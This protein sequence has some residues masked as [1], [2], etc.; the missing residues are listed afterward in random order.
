VD[1]CLRK[2]REQ[3]FETA[4]DLAAALLPFAPKRARAAVERAMAMARSAGQSNRDLE[5]TSLAHPSLPL[6]FGP[7]TGAPQSPMS[8]GPPM[9]PTMPSAQR[10]RAAESAP[11]T[12]SAPPRGFAEKRSTSGQ[13]ATTAPSG[14]D[15]PQKRRGLGA[16]A[17]VGA[18]V[19]V[20]A[21]TAWGVLRARSSSEAFTAV[22]PEA[23][24]A[25]A[26][27]PPNAAMSATALVSATAAA[28]VAAPAPVAAAVQEAK[29]D[30]AAATAVDAAAKV[31][32]APSAAPARRPAAAAAHTAQATPHPAPDLDI[33]MQR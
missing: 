1:R 28:T 8:S 7:A 6:T 20:V 22:H 33:R 14:V 3:R 16:F 29:P 10:A 4:A 17:A 15:E 26:A 12:L 23:V 13:L 32:P 5:A 19:V 11:P 27:A 30:R 31:E 21:I 9:T 2:D 25:P 24:P 18:A